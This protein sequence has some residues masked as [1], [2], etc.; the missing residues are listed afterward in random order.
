MK[1][2]IHGLED[3]RGTC[4]RRVRYE[5]VLLGATIF[6]LLSFHLVR[7][8]TLLCKGCRDKYNRCSPRP[9]DQLTWK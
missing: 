4:G 8:S 5:S 6:R 3:K 7:P 9:E 1:L 2:H